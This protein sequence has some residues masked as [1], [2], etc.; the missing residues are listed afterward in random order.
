MA[1]SASC[2]VL[3]VDDHSLMRE[4]LRILLSEIPNVTVVAEAADG[5]DAITLC[6][7]IQPSIVLM[8]LTLPELDGI[9]AIRQIHRRFPEI[10][11][12]ALTATATEIRAAEAL[13][14]G[15]S[16]YVLKRSGKKELLNAIEA[17]IQ[18]RV[19]L[20][21]ALDETQIEALITDP[22]KNTHHALTARERQVLKLVAQGNPNRLIAEVLVVSPKTVETHRLNLMQK[23][24]AHNA[25]ELTRWAYRLG[26]LNDDIL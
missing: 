7:S 20:D 3:I 22:N 2:T 15:A 26:L 11:I 5:R 14:A 10:R 8:D 4:G 1:A 6:R 23:L 19:Y 12:L 16:G 9:E 17:V 25:A 21:P 24:D 18:G 13:N